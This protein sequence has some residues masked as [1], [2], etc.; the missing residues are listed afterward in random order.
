MFVLAHFLSCSRMTY[1]YLTCCWPLRATLE[2]ERAKEDPTSD[3][4]RPHT[5]CR[6]SPAVCDARQQRFKETLL[7]C[8]QNHLRKDSL[9]CKGST[10]RL[11]IYPSTDYLFRWVEV[12]VWLQVLVAVDL[13]GLQTLCSTFQFHRSNCACVC[14]ISSVLNCRYCIIGNRRTIFFIM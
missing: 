1:S 2:V 13:N 11:V 10:R 5:L 9:F 8:K 3:Y 14:V 4:I 6:L 12:K 7:M